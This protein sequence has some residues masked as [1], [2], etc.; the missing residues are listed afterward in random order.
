MPTVSFSAT[1]SVSVK[2]GGSLWHVSANGKS[3]RLLEEERFPVYI[4]EEALG[5]ISHRL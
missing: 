5:D 3:S 4:A 2:I 1:N